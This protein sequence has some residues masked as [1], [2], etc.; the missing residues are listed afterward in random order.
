MKIKKITLEE[1]VNNYHRKKSQILCGLIHRTANGQQT[2]VRCF[3]AR[4]VAWADLYPFAVQ[5]SGRP[6]AVQKF[7]LCNA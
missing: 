7:L 1:N 4:R 2:V 3:S 5:T 6:F